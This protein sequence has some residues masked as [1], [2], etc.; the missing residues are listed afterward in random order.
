[1]KQD[2]K[3][4]LGIEESDSVAEPMKHMAGF[5]PGWCTR[6]TWA[7]L[8]QRGS[9]EHPPSWSCKAGRS[10]GDTWYSGNQTCC[11]CV[12]IRQCV[13]LGKEAR[14]QV[15]MKIWAAGSRWKRKKGSSKKKL[16]I[17]TAQL[18][19]RCLPFYDTSKKRGMLV[20]DVI[21]GLFSACLPGSNTPICGNIT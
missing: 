20:G 17:N 18:H 10:F 14:P 6:S 1:M 19:K 16:V 5:L 9:L 11:D 12:M 4:V 3:S 8:E 2:S 13:S 15:L 21:L 7:S